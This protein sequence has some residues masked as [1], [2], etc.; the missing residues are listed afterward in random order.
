RLLKAKK[1]VAENEERL[2][3]LGQ[4]TRG[5]RINRESYP[6]KYFAYYPRRD[7][8]TSVYT[9]LYLLR[10]LEEKGAF[11]LLLRKEKEG[12]PQRFDIESLPRRPRTTSYLRG[13]EKIIKRPYIGIDR[14]P[15]LEGSLILLSRTFINKFNVILR[16]SVNK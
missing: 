3:D 7:I 9:L 8:K 15:R 6:K 13:V 16:P 4:F 12:K 5:S 1:L 11:Y 14:D 10:V 2:R